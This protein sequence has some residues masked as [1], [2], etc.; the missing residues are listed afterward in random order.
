M[1]RQKPIFN[2]FF[3][4]VLTAFL[5]AGTSFSQTVNLKLIETSDVHGSLF[6]YDFIKA[7]LGNTSL[8]QLYTY[9]QQQR[10]NK[11]QS[12][13]LLDDG[14]I[15]QGQPIVY[16]YNFEKTDVPHIVSRVMNYMN[17]DAGTVGN[18][19]IEPGHPVYDKI[20]KEFNFPWLAAN[21]IN[22][23]TG[24]PYFKPYTIINRD[25]IKI[26]VLGMITPAIPNWLPKKIWSGIR[27]DDMVETAKKWVPIILKKEK[28][29]LM[30]GL[31]HSGVEAGYNNADPNAPKNE[32]A[33]QLVAEKV[34][35]FDI[36]FVGHDHHGWNYTI[37]NSEG[38]TVYILG[39]INAARTAAVA[40]VT[41]TKDPKTNKWDKK[42]SSEIIESK[43]YKEYAPMV[44]KFAHDI[45][46]CVSY[47]NKYIGSFTKSVSTKESMYGDSPF[48][49]LIQKIQLE[50]TKADVSFA[51]PLSFNAEIRSGGVRVR[52]MFSLYK[53]ENLLYTMELTGQEIKNYLEYSFGNWF[54]QMK[55][56]NDHLLNFKT[57]D[58]GNLVEENGHP[59]LN[60]QYYNFSSAAG[61]KYTVDVS[62]PAGQR[63]AIIS[64][65]DG[66]PFDLN[67]KYKVAINS[68][69]GNGGGGLL[70]KGAGIPH[71]KLADRVITSTQKDLRYYLMKWIQKHRHI[72][73]ESLNNWRVIPENWWEKGKEKDFKLLYDGNATTS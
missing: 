8:A 41:L 22:T 59:V 60:S 10:D 53:Y 65:S 42:I 40:N 14:D 5:F 37:K 28:P 63:V 55:D 20:D 2:K 68:Y 36:V 69:R 62:K 43:D 67:K 1:F 24:K 26:A 66:K 50:L 35:G 57:D 54:N 11:D 17:Y 32:N 48:V 39:T 18:H 61:I 71:E 70:T 29:D 30:I 7:K 12:V 19:D 34:P 3:V 33:S 52:D 45:E 47:V 9:I 72:S 4:I 23:K 38:K 15:L 31:F 73:P 44:R 21:A 6:Q 46:Q 25:G 27:F 56:E 16:Y 51:A 49:D 58:K 13:V 64:M